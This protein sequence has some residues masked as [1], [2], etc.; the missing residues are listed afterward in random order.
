MNFTFRLG[1][2]FQDTF[3]LSL[4]KYFQ[5]GKKNSKSAVFLAPSTLD[6][7]YRALLLCFQNKDLPCPPAHLFPAIWLFIAQPAGTSCTEAEGR[8]LPSLW[9]KHWDGTMVVVVVVETVTGPCLRVLLV[10]FVL[11]WPME[12]TLFLSSLEDVDAQGRAEVPLAVVTL[13]T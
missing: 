8:G 11:E 1:P 12:F 9:I 7:G 10:C 6:K 13:T 4:C 5:T 2:Y 3:S